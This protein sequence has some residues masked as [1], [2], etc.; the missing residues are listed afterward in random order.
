VKDRLEHPLSS[1][2]DTSPEKIT[3]STNIATSTNSLDNRQQDLLR[4]CLYLMSPPPPVM[5]RL[6][7]PDIEV[8]YLTNQ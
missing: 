4:R 2:N 1:P 8:E 6:S 5:S 3:S 7:V